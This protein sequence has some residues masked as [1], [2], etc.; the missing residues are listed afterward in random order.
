MIGNK[1][2]SGIPTSQ[3]RPSKD[4]GPEGSAIAE[5]E[6]ATVIKAAIQAVVPRDLPGCQ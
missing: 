4:P 2:P 3:K 6:M 5:N 1:N